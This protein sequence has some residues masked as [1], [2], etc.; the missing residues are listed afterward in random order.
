MD[1]RVLPPLSALRAFAAFA[2]TGSVVAAGEALGVSHAAISQQLRSLEAHL[3]VTLLDRAGR[4][5]TLTGHGAQLA[6]AALA[7][8]DGIAA[9]VEEITGAR[10]ARPLQVSTTASFAASWLMPRL[11]RF[12]SAHP[13]SALM[14][15]PTPAVVTL[16]AGGIDVAL[17]YGDGNWD[18]LVSEMI[19]QSPI[20]VVAAPSLVGDATE[21]T[22]E[23]LGDLPWLEEI[24]L[25][26]GSHWL[27]RR[28]VTRGH[29]RGVTELP[30]NLILDGARDG[31]GVAVLVRAF[32]EADIAAGRLRVLFTGDAPDNGY[33]MVTRPGVMRPALKDFVQ[34]LRREAAFSPARS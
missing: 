7:G 34:W 21:V 27:R 3:D 8:F 17:R 4:A 28:G 33:H 31:Q 9:A 12:R 14:I 20:V 25:S 13:D 29:A 26:E 30:G 32:V 5:M 16:S 22:L 19:L 18:G 15:N 1:W 10:D 11:P 24:G 23:Q 2:R 6:Q